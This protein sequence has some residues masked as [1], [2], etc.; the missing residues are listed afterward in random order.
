MHS[1]L[2]Y[3]REK[4]KLPTFFSSDLLHLSR[5]KWCQS[6][7]QGS[8]VVVKNLFRFR[9]RFEC[10]D[11]KNIINSKRPFTLSIERNYSYARNLSGSL[12]SPT[13][14]KYRKP[15][16]NLLFR[17]ST[18]VQ[19]IQEHFTLSGSLNSIFVKVINQDRNHICL[20]ILAMWPR[21]NSV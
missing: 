10:C 21:L 18:I 20:M 16:L 3:S 1:R 6:L 5:N 9:I 13:P 11:Y 2:S 19:P 17:C 4:M 15:T 7:I 8:L 14:N 12:Q